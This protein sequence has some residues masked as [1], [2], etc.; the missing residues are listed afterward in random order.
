LPLTFYLSPLHGHAVAVSIERT[1]ED[2]L[3]IDH[4]SLYPALHRLVRRGWITAN[5][6]TSENNCRA[7]FYR[8]TAAGR[9][10]LQAEASTEHGGAPPTVSYNSVSPGYFDV[11]G[12]RVLR[13]R[14]VSRRTREIGVRIALGAQRS[15]LLRLV[16]GHALK[17]VG[18]GVALSV[19][20]ALA[21]R[22]LLSGLLLGLVSVD[23]ILLAGCALLL[24]V[25]AVTASYIPARRA[26]RVDPVT[27]L[28]YE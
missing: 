17:L 1:T 23:P 16:L 15:S 19:L 27:A 26:T 24:A 28:R 25:V 11:L 18:L 12:G 3:R 20:G 10:Q 6:G 22:G 9:R 2:V 14:A 4:G 13:G 8:L 7:K 5:W 21:L